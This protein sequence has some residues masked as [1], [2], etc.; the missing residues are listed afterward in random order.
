MDST[1]PRSGNTAP[2]PNA[3]LSVCKIR[4]CTVN[5]ATRPAKRHRGSRDTHR[6]RGRTDAQRH[7]DHTDEPHNLSNPRTTH[8][9]NVSATTE[10]AADSHSLKFGGE[11]F[12][13]RVSHLHAAEIHCVLRP[14]ELSITSLGLCKKVKTDSLC[15]RNLF[16][17]PLQNP[18]DRRG[19]SSSLVYG[20]QYFQHS[21]GAVR[22]GLS[23]RAVY[24]PSIHWLYQILYQALSQL[25]DCAAHSVIA[26]SR[27][28]RQ[29]HAPS[30]PT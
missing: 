8:N 26:R 4:T 13:T 2:S 3:S 10:A 24:M 5:T 7:T 28:L 1:H 17:L 29:H 30:Q 14:C 16:K 21:A 9:P 19:K 11:G 27:T 25:F 15:S 12:H 6:T 22:T 20:P 23:V 18:K